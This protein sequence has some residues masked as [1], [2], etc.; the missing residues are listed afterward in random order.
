MSPVGPWLLKRRGRKD[1]CLWGFESG[2]PW[3]IRETLGAPE[4]KGWNAWG[5]SLFNPIKSQ[6]KKWM[7]NNVA[8]SFG[9]KEKAKHQNI[10]WAEAQNVAW[11]WMQADFFWGTFLSLSGALSVRLMYNSL[12]FKP[13]WPFCFSNRRRW[14]R[15]WEFHAAS[16]SLFWNSI[17]NIQQ[18]L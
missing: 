5:M 3:S 4:A 7:V 16:Y 2:L 15:I 10:Q 1:P 11:M 8:I 6:G 12:H 9:A 14:G 17:T 13:W 18:Q